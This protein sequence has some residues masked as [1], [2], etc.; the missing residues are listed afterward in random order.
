MKSSIKYAAFF[1]NLWDTCKVR[2]SDDKWEDKEITNLEYIMSLK[3]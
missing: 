2:N 3:N 1:L